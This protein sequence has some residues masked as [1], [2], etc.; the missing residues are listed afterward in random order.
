MED[1]YLKIAERIREAV[2]EIDHI[3]EDTGQLYPVQY[4]D[5]YEYPIL[6][7]CLLIDASTID[8]KAEKIGNMQRGTAT[9]TLRLAFRVDEDTHFEPSSFND[10]EQLRLRKH[11][12][13]RVVSAL[14]C[15]CLD[16]RMSAMY[17]TQSRSYS[18][19]GRVRVY[20]STFQVNVTERL[21][22][23]GEE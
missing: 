2:P 9:V 19:P 18:Q 4:D 11:I 21:S 16:E 12:E 23:I 20:E 22:E 13:H 5:R 15:Y 7:P 10:F 14:H 8:W 1:L 3:D 17:R 6:F